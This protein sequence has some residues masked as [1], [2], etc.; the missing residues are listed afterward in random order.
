VARGGYWRT[1]S[2]AHAIRWNRRSLEAY[3]D[4][5]DRLFY[6]AVAALALCVAS[7]LVR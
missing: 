3:L 4:A 1:A 6:A 7:M 5:V 2:P